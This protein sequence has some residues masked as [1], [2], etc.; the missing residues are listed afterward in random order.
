MSTAPLTVR[1]T[2]RVMTLMQRLQ[3]LACD[4]GVDLRGRQGAV[5][6]QQLHHAQVSAVIHQVGG[7]R[8]AQRVW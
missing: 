5:A 6:E 4:M 2:P 1:S 3:T 8:M 7:E